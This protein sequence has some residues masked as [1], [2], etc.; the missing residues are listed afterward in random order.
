MTVG[1]TVR[2]SATRRRLRPG[3]K[4]IRVSKQANVDCVVVTL[5]VYVVI[6]LVVYDVVITLV[7]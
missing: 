4:A 1:T 6:T 5:V 3:Q 7:V 2:K